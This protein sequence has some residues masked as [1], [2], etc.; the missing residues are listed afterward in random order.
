MKLFGIEF[1][2]KTQ[3]LL[4]SGREII[5]DDTSIINEEEILNQGI[6]ATQKPLN[7]Q[8]PE[9]QSNIVREEKVVSEEVR[10]ARESKTINY[11][12]TK[13]IRTGVPIDMNMLMSIAGENN[14]EK[15]YPIVYRY[16]VNNEY[17]EVVLGQLANC[18]QLSD[19]A[20]KIIELFRQQ[21]VNNAQGKEGLEQIEKLSDMIK[22]NPIAGIPRLPFEYTLEG[23]DILSQKDPFPKEY[24][25]TQIIRETTGG[26]EID[27]IYTK[28]EIAELKK[29]K[30]D[31]LIRQEKLR[32]EQQ[33]KIKEKSKAQRVRNENLGL[34]K[35]DMREQY[36]IGEKIATYV[37]EKNRCS[38]INGLTNFCKFA[39]SEFMLEN[40]ETEKNEEMDVKS[41]LESFVEIKEKGF[42]GDVIYFLDEMDNKI[43]DSIGKKIEENKSEAIDSRVAKIEEIQKY[44]LLFKL[45]EAGR[46]N[47]FNFLA[48]D[49]NLNLNQLADKFMKCGISD[50]EVLE[51]LQ[52][53][54]EVVDK[55][56]ENKDITL[57][58]YRDK[59]GVVKSYYKFM[60]ESNPRNTTKEAEENFIMMESDII[61]TVMIDSNKKAMLVY[62]KVAGDSALYHYDT[63][64]VDDKSLAPNLKSKILPEIIKDVYKVTEQEIVN[65]KDS[66]LKLKDLQEL[67][68]QTEKPKSQQE[69][70]R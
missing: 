33:L 61:S 24:T 27:G 22:G 59:D 14:E 55:L 8:E 42:A 25:R 35:K 50:E 45:L 64:K 46:M 53:K 70:E 18:E 6:N 28:K 57:K 43:N 21:L 7:V 4:D 30:Q 68:E 54:Q 47:N 63:T 44:R 48:K 23:M 16:R 17:Y 49:K 10:K 1:G 66:N 29:Q 15:T 60:L 36:L 56:K 37:S 11:S 20:K 62:S 51:F 9:K 38:N 19:K 41:S 2:K 58:D 67:S 39:V 5:K 40:H 31:E 52:H 13:T 26:M 12:P 32:K 3:P 65:Y 34:M 69:E